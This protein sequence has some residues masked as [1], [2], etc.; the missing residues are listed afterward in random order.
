MTLSALAAGLLNF[1]DRVGRLS[2]ALFSLVAVAIMLYA[3]VTYH[4]RAQ[5]I[6]NRGSG[7]YDDRLGTYRI[8]GSSVVDGILMHFFQVRR[9]CPSFFLPR[10]LST[11][12]SVSTSNFLFFS[13]VS[14]VSIA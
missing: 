10:L 8:Y 14:L 1:G 7:P 12:C 11:L 2:A 4:W 9:F 6:R 13:H 3:L 5:A